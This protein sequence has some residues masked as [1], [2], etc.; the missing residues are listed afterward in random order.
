MIKSKRKHRKRGGIKH[1]VKIKI[2]GE[3]RFEITLKDSITEY[4]FFGH[5]EEICSTFA[6]PINHVS[7][8]QFCPFCGEDFRPKSILY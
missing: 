4:Q 6:V 5:K 1:R 7:A 2:T 3:G 8:I